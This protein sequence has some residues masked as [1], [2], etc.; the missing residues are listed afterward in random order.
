VSQKYGALRVAYADL[1]QQIKYGASC[2][3]CQVYRAGRQDEESE[4]IRDFPISPDF[5][6]TSDIQKESVDVGV[7]RRLDFPF[8]AV[9]IGSGTSFV[10]QRL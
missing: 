9:K 5:Y 10:Q 8:C 4:F 6:N 1:S 7:K 3:T 2:P